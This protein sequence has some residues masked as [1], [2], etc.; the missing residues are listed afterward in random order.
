MLSFTTQSKQREN[1]CHHA[2][3]SCKIQPDSN[4][5]SDI[6]SNSNS[7]LF[8]TGHPMFAHTIP[9]NMD[10]KILL[11]K[12]CKCKLWCSVWAC[13]NSSKSYYRCITQ[14]GRPGTCSNTTKACTVF[15]IMWGYYFQ[16]HSQFTDLLTTFGIVVFKQR[17]WL[18]PS[19][20]C[21]IY[22]VDHCFGQSNMYRCT[23]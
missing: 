20:V 1:D 10:G 11:Y 6:N 13:D 2:F 22:S 16:S 15:F 8:Q 9:Y 17:Q 21:S 7:V 4:K 19:A 23:L 12:Y 3:Q 18:L 5:P 14:T